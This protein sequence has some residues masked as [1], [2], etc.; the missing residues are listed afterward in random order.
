MCKNTDYFPKPQPT[1]YVSNKYACI[2][3]DKAP[4]LKIDPNASPDGSWIVLMRKARDWSGGIVVVVVVVVVV[5]FCF[6]LF[7]FVLLCRWD[8]MN[9]S[10]YTLFRKHYFKTL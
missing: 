3:H 1:V 8:H 7:C 4:S 9:S 10:P 6:V 2:V 5:L